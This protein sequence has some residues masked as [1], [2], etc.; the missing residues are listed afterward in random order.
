MQPSTPQMAS[1]FMPS[2]ARASSSKAGEKSRTATATL[3]AHAK[4]HAV[5]EGASKKAK[6]NPSEG[7]ISSSFPNEDQPMDT[8]E[9]GAPLPDV[10][11]ESPG[12]PSEPGDPAL[13]R[14]EAYMQ[15]MMSQMNSLSCQVS[16]SEVSVLAQ[17]REFAKLGEVM[18]GLGTRMANL[19]ESTA[20]L[21]RD[22]REHVDDR[23]DEIAAAAAA[24]TAAV[25]SRLVQL[26][27]ELDAVASSARASTSSS[28]A[29][30]AG[31][32]RAAGPSGPGRP[33]PARSDEN[34]IIIVRDFPEELPRSVL[35]D[36]FTDLLLLAPGGDR[37]E[38]H[39]R[40]N[41]VDKQIVMVFPSAAKADSFFEA[42]KAKEPIYTDRDCGRDYKL[43]A[44][45]GRPLAVRRR[46]GATHPVY[47]AAADII[48]KKD[49]FENAT[50]VPNPRMRAGVMHTEFHA[51]VGRKVTALFSIVFRE[52]PQETVIIDLMFARNHRF[53]EDECAAIRASASLQ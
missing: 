19:E 42:F 30:P 41:P 32:G 12:G 38:I 37:S 18:N 35:K 13:V 29:L 34:C 15:A 31:P 43:S 20:D 21:T 39:S 51:Q 52:D 8:A 3:A 44:K 45:K 48:K 49:G 27:L 23:F 14:M 11:S 17:T 9:V 40:I 4:E 24:T 2:T 10:R 25:D 22:I 6:H 7:S 46:G 5:K 33:G 36:T 53:T 28:S 26:K 16:K 47:A 50:I 1:K